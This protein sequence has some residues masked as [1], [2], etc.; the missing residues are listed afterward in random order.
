MR[1][2]AKVGALATIGA[3]AVAVPATAHP[4]SPPPHPSQSH[5]CASHNVAY[6]VYGTVDSTQGALTLTK[7]SN[8]TYSTTGSLIV[9][10]T[11]TNHWAKGEKTGMQPRTFALTLSTKIRLGQGLTT[12]AAGDRVKLIGKERVSASKCNTPPA[13]P[14]FTMV[15]VHPPAKTS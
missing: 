14:T 12:I 5:K 3:L 7:N 10:V 1:I 9:H 8:G 4:G 11:S 15:V 13:S 2:H 6:I